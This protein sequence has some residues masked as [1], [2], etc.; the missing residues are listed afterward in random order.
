MIREPS[1]RKAAVLIASLDA[2]TADLL[3][4]QMPKDQ[5]EMVRREIV[6]IDEIDPS[7]QQAVLD[8]FFRSGPIASDAGRAEIG[9]NSELPVQSR[10]IDDRDIVGYDDQPNAANPP[11][12]S[13]GRASLEAVVAA[14]E[15]EHPQA[16]ALVLTH[17]PPDRAGQVLARL[18]AGA[19]TEVIRRLV[20]SSA[21]DPQVLMEV[22]LAIARRLDGH[23]SLGKLA[24]GVASLKAILHASRPAAR[25]QI[26]SNLAAHDRRLA[27]QIAP[28]SPAKRFTF[29]EVCG[30]P[31]ES[32]TCLFRDADRRTAVL[33]LAGTSAELVDEFLEALDPQEADWFARRLTNLGPL[34]LADI[35]R[36]QEDLAA[37]ASQLLSEGRLEGYSSSHLTAVV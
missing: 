32:L 20:D 18:P 8:E 10:G 12:S 17:L 26:L 9:L 29:S 6:D 1:L 30:L 13:L 19:Q 2:D 25:R 24:S 31:L 21:T 37:L 23:D 27:H 22:E 28:S 36:A 5:A 4:A 33:A 34:R 7:E 11:F 16:V 3:L 14:L 35:D 15:R